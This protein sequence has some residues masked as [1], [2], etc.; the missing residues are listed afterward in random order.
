MAS[1][2]RKI[3]GGPPATGAELRE[4][5][6][7]QYQL[8]STPA[9]A[10][11]DAAA[12]ALDIAAAADATIQRD[13]LIL[14]GQRGSRAHPAIVIARDARNQVIAALRALNLELQ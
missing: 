12:R 3:T 10:L 7:A 14:G 11:L 5:V 2:R 6:L 4:R 8:T 9:L 13:G 1:K